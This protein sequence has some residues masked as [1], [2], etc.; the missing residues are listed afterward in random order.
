MNLWEVI[1][2]KVTTSSV[3]L[4]EGRL[5]I[6]GVWPGQGWC[7]FEIIFQKVISHINGVWPS[8]L[9]FPASICKI[10][11]IFISVHVMWALPSI[12]VT[13]GQASSAFFLANSGFLYNAETEMSTVD[14][15]ETLAEFNVFELIQRMSDKLDRTVSAINQKGW[16]PSFKT[17]HRVWT[18]KLEKTVSTLQSE[19]ELS[20]AESK[21]LLNKG[22]GKE[23][24]YPQARGLKTKL[25]LVG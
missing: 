17:S 11:I 25:K 14:E 18:R 24:L 16:G 7:R 3:W 23:N 4:E 19:V 9:A 1:T 22:K 8:F 12:K 13:H 15:Q 20:L 6:E 2:V 5:K 21:K 10:T